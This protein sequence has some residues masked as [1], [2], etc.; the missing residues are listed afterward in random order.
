M[1][2]EAESVSCSMLKSLG[3]KYRIKGAKARNNMSG[4]DTLAWI[5]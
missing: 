1:V 5:I 3:M 4:T 2:V